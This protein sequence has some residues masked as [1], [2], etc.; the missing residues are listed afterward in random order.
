MA[1]AVAVV[2]V[3]AVVAGVAARRSGPG[4]RP[5]APASVGDTGASSSRPPSPDASYWDP[6]RM[7]SA[8]PAPM[9]TE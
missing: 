3:V 9:P 8:E 7:A 6:A 2:V 5:A 4:E 1:V